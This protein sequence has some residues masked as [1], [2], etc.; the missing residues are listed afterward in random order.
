[1]H[2]RLSESLL[3]AFHHSCCD[4]WLKWLVLHSVCFHSCALQHSCE[5]LTSRCRNKRDVSNWYNEIR[6]CCGN[7]PWGSRQYDYC[8][9]QLLE[10]DTNIAGRKKELH[11]LESF[12]V[13]RHVKKSEA[14]DGTHLRVKSTVHN[15]GDFVRWRFASLEVNQYKRHDVFAGT[16]TSAY[17]SQKQQVTENGHRKIIAI[18]DVV[19][20]FFHA[21]LQ[22]ARSCC[23]WSR[24]ITARGKPLVSDRSCFAMKFSWKL[25]GTQWRWSHMCITSPGVWV[26][27]MMQVCVCVHVRR[28][29]G[30]VEDRCG[31]RSDNDVVIESRHQCDLNHWTRSGNWCQDRQTSLVLELDSH[32]KQIPS[33]RVIFFAWAGVA[34]SRAGAPSPGTVA[35]PNT[36]RNAL[37]VLPWER[38][39]AVSSAGGTATNLAMDRSDVAYSIRR[40]NQDIAKPKVRTEARLKR[41]AWYRLCEPDLT[42]TFPY[43]EMPTKSVVRT[44][45]NWTGQDTEFQ[46]CFREIWSRRRWCCVL[47]TRRDFVERPRVQ[48][49]R[50]DFWRS[51]RYSHQEHHQRFAS[52][53]DCAVG[54]WFNK[55]LRHLSTPGCWPTETFTQERA[56]AGRSS[57]SQE[58]RGGTSANWGQWR[59]FRY[60]TLGTSS[61]QEVCD[62]N[63]TVLC[64]G[65]GWRTVA[66]GVVSGSEVLIGED[67]R[68]G[69]SWTMDGCCVTRRCWSRTA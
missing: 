42:W 21:D 29:H 2:V 5:T 55:G 30:G 48:V 50:D 32:G 66:C 24:L 43:Q 26:M 41:V 44:D 23:C 20:A 68:E 14:T 25:V 57:R 39:K 27:T 69:Q 60:E 49:S 28:L 19:V 16:P 40:A 35:T 47:K 31:S 12:A 56:M 62:E 46:L 67:V 18:L 4:W 38:A 53:C 9:E 36:M 13:I 7:S 1:M 34:Q 15:E 59:R 64:R 54:N 10:R 45:T 8:T 11:Q 33:T 3:F 61:Y 37:D 65:F 6:F 63:G 22:E 52:G 17:L 58:R 51:I